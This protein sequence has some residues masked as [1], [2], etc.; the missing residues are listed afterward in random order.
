VL[1]HLGHPLV[2]SSARLLRAAVWSGQTGLHRVTA[3]V[4]DD[5]RVEGP[6]ARLEDERRQITTS[7][8]RFA[9][10]LRHALAESEAEAGFP[11]AV[12]FVVPRR[13]AVR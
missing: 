6:A 8:E 10:T 5:P 11:V 9:A 4:S 13:E 7:V 2:D 1:A 12:I 3:V